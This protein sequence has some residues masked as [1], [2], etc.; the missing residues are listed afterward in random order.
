VNLLERALAL[1]P[2]GDADRDRLLIDLATVLREQGL[3]HDA[4]SHLRA[5]RRS[6]LRKAD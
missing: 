2:P 5:A 4:E 6:S 1:Q 3:F